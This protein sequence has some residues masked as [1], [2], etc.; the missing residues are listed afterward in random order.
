MSEKMDSVKKFAG[1]NRKK[2][3][4]CA[5]AVAIIALAASIIGIS[6]KNYKT[7]EEYDVQS[8]HFTDLSTNED[9]KLIA[10]RGFRAIAPESSL[11][12][13]EMAGQAGYWGAEADVFRT[14]D[15]VWVISH[16][17]KTFRLMNKSKKIEDSTFEELSK[18]TYE[19]GNSLENYQNLGI[20][21]LDDYLQKCVQFN[22]RPVIELKGKNDSDNYGEIVQMVNEYKLEAVYTSF[23]KDNLKEMR[24]ITDAKLFLNSQKLNNKAI[25]QAKE[26]KNCGIIFNVE[27]NGNMAGD[28]KF[29]K[30]A[31]KQKLEVGAWNV[32]DVETVQTLVSYGANYIVTDCVTY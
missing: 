8:I 22:M 20:C 9:L 17:E 26:I 16:D 4:I 30:K 1:N 10:H 15:G 13:Y 21:K 14:K 23:E 27:K 5:I 29:V 3:I 28:G 25:S 31:V 24:K 19:H 7:P 6:V 2:I 18:L 12:A 32:N 11:P